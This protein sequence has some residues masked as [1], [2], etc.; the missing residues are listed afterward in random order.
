[1]NRSLIKNTLAFC[2]GTKYIQSKKI[3]IETFQQTVV[4]PTPQQYGY[5]SFS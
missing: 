5:N 3:E 1:M 4:P 2:T